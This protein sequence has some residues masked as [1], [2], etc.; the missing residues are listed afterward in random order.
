MKGGRSI[1]LRE[2][3]LFRAMGLWRGH[4]P[5]AMVAATQSPPPQNRICRQMID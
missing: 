1:L 5:A 4:R 3:D 2:R